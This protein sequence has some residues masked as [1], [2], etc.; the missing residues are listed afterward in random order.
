ME[1]LPRETNIE[2][3]SDTVTDY[4]KSQ[5]FD[6]TEP[7]RKRKKINVAPGVSVTSA[8]LRPETTDE[9]DIVLLLETNSEGEVQIKL[10]DLPE[11]ETPSSDN[12]NIRTFLLVTVKSDN[13]KK[14][15]FKYVAM[16]KNIGENMYHIIGFN[17]LDAT[18]TTFKMCVNDVFDIELQE[19]LLS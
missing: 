10:E 13:R 2:L 14:L 4:L 11:H 12:I 9:D 15:H 5:R 17:S 6:K 7:N 18:K 8:L 16:V 1:K 19:L 3:F